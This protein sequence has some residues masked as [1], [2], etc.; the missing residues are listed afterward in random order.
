MSQGQEHFETVPTGLYIGYHRQDVLESL[1]VLWH[2]QDSADNLHISQFESMKPSIVLFE[3]DEESVDTY[4][5]IAQ[6]M[7]NL[8]TH[9]A[10]RSDIQ[11]LF[12][13]VTGTDEQLSSESLSFIR[14]ADMPVF[15]SAEQIRA[16]I[17]E[18]ELLQQASCGLVDC[19]DS[20]S[21]DEGAGVSLAGAPQYVH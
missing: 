8:F 14:R 20:L 17:S 13:F 10:V 16:A 15:S 2:T 12:A 6:E 11:T 18:V 7:R 4:L 3:I 21:A 1:N 5:A 9:L 19:P